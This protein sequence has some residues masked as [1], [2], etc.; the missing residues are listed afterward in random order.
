MI[1]E[2]ERWFFQDCQITNFSS[3]YDIKLS[4]PFGLSFVKA[5]R[6]RVRRVDIP[7]KNAP[8]TMAVVED[9]GSKGTDGIIDNDT[10][11]LRVAKDNGFVK[12]GTEV[13]K[14]F[15]DAS[16]ISDLFGGPRCASSASTPRGLPRPI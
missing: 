4:V 1:I 13:L 7:P 16:G 6:V 3:D 14:F 5:R 9:E 15:G 2:A 11:L 10:S 8:A 12:T